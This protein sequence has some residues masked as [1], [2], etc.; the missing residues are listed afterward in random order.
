VVQLSRLVP[1]FVQREEIVNVP[2]LHEG[3]MAP[4]FTLSRSGG[5]TVTLS[6]LRGQHVVVYF[7]PKD[8]TP[9]C[10]VEACNF[11]D[12]QQDIEGTGAV[13][14]GISP[15]S[16]AS[17]DR[18]AG[19]YGLPFALLS[20]ENRTVAEQYGVWQERR[21]YGKTYMGIVRSTFLVGPDGKLVRI[22]NNVKPES[23]TREVL[24]ALAA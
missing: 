10:T 17:H 15:D 14:L 5:G 16:V 2:E 18:F 4:D 13:V 12:A 19:K 8:D 23:H 6:D 20:D 22:W 24:E 7:Y 11:R 9:G 3:D 21:N 1:L